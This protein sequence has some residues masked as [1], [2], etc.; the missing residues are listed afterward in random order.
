MVSKVAATV[1]P[2]LNARLLG[3]LHSWSTRSAIRRSLLRLVKQGA[4]MPTVELN[5]TNIWY[6]DTGGYGP[7][8]LF[9]HGYNSS[10]D[11]WAMTLERL[12]PSR[13]YI[14]MD[15]RGAGDSGRPDDDGYTI[16][17][18]VADV[19]GV[20]THL[21][22]DTFTYVGHSMGGAI[23]FTLGLEHADRL[24]KLVLVAPIPSGGITDSP[25]REIVVNQW[26][27]GDEDAMVR[28]RIV[29]VARP[30]SVDETQ[31]KASVGRALSVSRGH[32]EQS[33]ETMRNFDVSDRLS[34]IG[35]PTLMMAGAAD[36]LVVANLR[37][38]LSLPNASLHVFHRVG[39]GPPTEV[40]DEFVSVLE[41]FLS[42]GVVRA[43]TLLDRIEES[44]L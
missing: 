12:A 13:R 41:D 19:I 21:G 6:S 17:A 31:I 38:Y 37:D 25:R 1:R 16:D 24:D 44:E 40:P 8:V 3:S 4:F 22:I 27:S 2:E 23:G 7:V 34:E 5:G 39:H 30:E 36:G 32:Y 42:Y 14:T 26:N 9:H 15:A 18:Y 11:N 29:G 28:E 35:T 20:T 33:W 10:H 43:R